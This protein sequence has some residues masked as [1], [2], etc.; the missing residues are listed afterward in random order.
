MEE[1]LIYLDP[2]RGIEERVEDLL[3]RMTLDEKINQMYTTGCN[4]LEPLLERAKKGEKLD[5]SASFV[6][7]GYNPET[8]NELQR[9]QLQNSRLKIPFIL[10]CENT[11]GVS[12]PLCT[13][14]PTTGCM[15][16]T[17]DEELIGKAAE[18]SAKEARILGITQVYAPNIDIT[19]EQ[20]WGR[21]EENF[22]E[23]PYLTS[24][25][26]VAFVKNFQK[27][28]VAATVKHYIAYGLGES[29]LNLAPAHI[30]ERDIREY[31]LPPFEACVKEGGAWSLMPSYNEVDGEPVHA[32]KYWMKEVL[33]EELGFDGMI[34][35]DYG[36]SNMLYGFH[37]II[38]KPVEAG[39]ILCDNEIDT[40]GCSFFGYNDEFRMLVKEGKY[41]EEKIDALVR[42]ILRM[43]FRLG[44]FENPFATL[45]KSNTIHCDEHVSLAREIA[46]KGT[47]LLK[48]DGVL[49]LNSEKKIA[50]IGPNAD[51][52]QLGNYIYYGY[53]DESY[54]GKCV[55]EE[56]LS[57]RGVL[58]KANANFV[59]E[60]GSEFEKTDDE[61]LERAYHAAKES[62]VVV[63]ALGDNSKGGKCCGSQE[64][65]KRLGVTNVAVTSG[66]GYDLHSI[67]LTPAQ[68]KLFEKVKLAGKPIIML[69]YG[70]RPHAITRQVDDCS[71]ILFAFGAGE[72]GNEAIYDILLGKVNPSGKLPLTFPRS[73]GHLPCF[74][75]YKPSARGSFYQRP[76]SEEKPGNDYVFENPKALFPFGY[77]LSY[78]QYEYSNLQVNVAGRY[79]FTVSVDVENVGEYDGE[80]SVL[81]FLSTLVQRTTPMVKRLRAFKR[82]ALKKGEKKTVELF[83]TKEDFLYVGVDM[84]KQAS[85]GRHIV[86]IGDLSTEIVV[87]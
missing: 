17:F 24:R 62:D 81:L 29:G 79:A 16:A 52:S 7:F 5:I 73:T 34:I 84:K 31:M 51:V 8:Y 27:E 69:L 67:E 47:V 42:N 6:Y 28:G 21:V 66:E 57:L 3:K 54:K 65:L 10:A 44:L 22:G 33:R 83:L 82:V 48:N 43:K 13:I 36:A 72:Q 85:T 15:A 86:R 38:N 74:Y 45:E 20:R 14:F 23:D 55:A 30:G 26:G 58:E 39:V 59:Y 60:K 50:L 56:S 71:A 53:F 41:P 40:E 77:G 75:N 80:E 12:N 2:T 4:E 46:E 76:G 64:D 87:E 61:L 9:Y 18:A 25:M 1:K 78:T 70:G 32:S 37:H 68:E 11:H 19:W 35:T 63:L 49:P